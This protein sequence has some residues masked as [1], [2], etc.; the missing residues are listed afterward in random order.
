[1]TPRRIIAIALLSLGVVGGYG[2]G[3]WHLSHHHRCHGQACAH[4]HER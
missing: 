3:I 2:S 4:W 1:M